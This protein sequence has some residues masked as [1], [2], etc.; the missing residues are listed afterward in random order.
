[1][2]TKL[3]EYLVKEAAR[4]HEFIAQM[5]PANQER[6]GSA[7]YRFLNN[8]TTQ[9]RLAKAKALGIPIR[10]PKTG[11]ISEQFKE[12]SYSPAKNVA[13]SKDEVI[14]GI[15]R[16]SD[17]L[18]KRLGYTEANVTGATPQQIEE[19]KKSL[20]RQIAKN[21]ADNDK[22]AL[23]RNTAALNNMKMFNGKNVGSSLDIDNIWD[24]SMSPEVKLIFSK[25]LTGN[26]RY[27]GAILRRHELQEAVEAE[28]LLKNYYRYP[29]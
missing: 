9:Q 7:F 2:I 25:T 23:R 17:N 18:I 4:W 14:A 28:K 20:E 13:K 21:K 11:K 26:N 19:A 3:G 10:D 24:S 6:L 15:N 29:G 22:A 1:M 5:S 16:G 8:S 27:T 12:L